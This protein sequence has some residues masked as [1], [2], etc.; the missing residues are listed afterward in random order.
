MYVLPFDIPD[1]INHIGSR[2]RMFY[3]GRLLKESGVK[4]LEY[5]VDG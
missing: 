1:L 4:R 3:Y 5:R 2:E